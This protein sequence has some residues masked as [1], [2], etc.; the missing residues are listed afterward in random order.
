MNGGFPIGGFM[1]KVVQILKSKE[2]WCIG[3]QHF[4]L[5]FKIIIFGFKKIQIYKCPF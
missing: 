1:L 5:K 3:W 2:L 4:I